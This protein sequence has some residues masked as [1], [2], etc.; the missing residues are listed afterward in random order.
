MRYARRPS[1]L[2]PF[3]RQE[4]Q[5][6]LGHAPQQVR[7]ARGPRQD[8]NGDHGAQQM[9]GKGCGILVSRHPPL[10]LCRLDGTAKAVFDLPQAG[11]D[12]GAKIGIMGAHFR[13]GV[14]E[15]AAPAIRK[16]STI[17]IVDTITP[18]PEPLPAAAPHNRRPRSDAYPGTTVWSP[19][20]AAA[21]S[22]CSG[23]SG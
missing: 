14:D 9:P 6:G 7:I 16:I 18:R 20:R 2:R 3:K 11:P 13:R 4:G 5:G 12:R 19:A 22:A 23:R 17:M 21:R 8:A 1:T 10:A 15:Q